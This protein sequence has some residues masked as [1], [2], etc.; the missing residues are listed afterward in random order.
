MRAQRRGEAF[1]GQVQ[2]AV[3]IA[4][5]QAHVA[6]VH[7]LAALLCGNQ[8]LIGHAADLL[9]VL[10]GIAVDQ[11]G[12]ALLE[13]AV[14]VVHD[15]ARGDDLERAVNRI[16]L[17]GDVLAQGAL[18]G[19]EL[20][21]LEGLQLGGDHRAGCIQAQHPHQLGLLRARGGDGLEKADIQQRLVA[22]GHVVHD[23]AR[24][25][26]D[27]DDAVVRL[28]HER[29]HIAAARAGELDRVGHLV[30]VDQAAPAVEDVQVVARPGDDALLR[31]VIV[32]VRADLI[33]P[34]VAAGCGHAV[35]RRA[36][37]EDH[38][39]AEGRHVLGERRADARHPAHAFPARATERIENRQ[40]DDSGEHGQRQ[41]HAQALRHRLFL[42]FPVVHAVGA[43]RAVCAGHVRH[44][45]LVAIHRC[46][47]FPFSHFSTFGGIQSLIQNVLAEKGPKSFG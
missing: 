20:A 42:L 22:D 44:A 28:A 18:A 5:H 38:A 40:D 30:V 29:R 4:V 33:A 46:F 7:A 24:L 12:V 31:G 2:H 6:D 32:R 34:L 27:G 35:Q 45:L 16:D 13:H 39:V 37:V 19:G 21:G 9:H 8:Q 1:A 36:V 47:L 43:Q 26:D 11:R 10:H 41:E 15:L 23:L 25:V 14:V 3:D 17:V